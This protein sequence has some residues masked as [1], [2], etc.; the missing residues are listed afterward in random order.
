MRR[1]LF[2]PALLAAA[3]LLSCQEP[4]EPAASL[5]VAS[6][7][8]GG[9]DRGYARAVTP[10]DFQFP[11]DHGPHPGFRT[12]WWYYTGSL[13]TREGRRLGFQLTFFRSALAPESPER[14]SAWGA[15]EAWL[16]HFTVTDAEG[17]R[18][19]SFERWSRGAVGLAGARAEPF[20][21]WLEDW[22]AE[23]AG[24]RPGQP[25]PPMRLRAEQDGAAI[26]LVLQ[27]GKPPV[28]QGDRGLSQ[29]G[30]E[31]GNASYYY[32]LTRMPA[33]GTVRVGG[34]RFQVSGLAWMDREWSTSS[35]SADQVG[36]DWFALQLDDGT[37]LMLYRLRKKDG[38]ADPLSSATVA[39]PAG[40]T[41]HLSLADF[42]LED[43]ERWT[44]PRSGGVY[45]ARWRVRIPAE[46]LDL[47]VSPLLADQELDVSFRYWEGAVAVE[48]RHRGQPVRGRGY[49]EMTGYTGEISAR[50]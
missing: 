44:S 22:T 1:I 25:T 28:L 36:W 32:S 45:P 24:A 37:D 8:R 6:A 3:C 40:E 42:R 2:F 48:G 47:E 19:V 10:R 38:S 49:V 41:R 11:A 46:D 50:H 26:D 15:N 9:D 23:A 31:P 39:G 33:S 27:P 34:E 20:R 5:S 43:L 17:G 7:L 16:A 30:P 14:E 4:R 29:K 18:F 21:V 12:E 13:A 35:L